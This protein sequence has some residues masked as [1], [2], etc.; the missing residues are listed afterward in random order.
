M[1]R[2]YFEYVI[3]IPSGSWVHSLVLKR[4]RIKSPHGPSQ[5]KSF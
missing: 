3:N 2:I 5:V 4:K 1:S